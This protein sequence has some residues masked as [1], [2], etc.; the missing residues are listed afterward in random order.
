MSVLFS[1]K[2]N[3]IKKKRKLVKDVEE[4]TIEVAHENT[5]VK[6]KTIKRLVQNKE[7]LTNIRGFQRSTSKNK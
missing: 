2:T 1:Y 4:N 3:T 7:S 5:C 6:K